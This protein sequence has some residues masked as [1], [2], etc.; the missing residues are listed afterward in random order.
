MFTFDKI[1]IH[2]NSMVVHDDLFLLGTCFI[3]GVVVHQ[4]QEASFSHE[5]MTQAKLGMYDVGI[6]KTCL[7]I[8]MN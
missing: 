7:N 1:M 8:T 2:G 4:E 6:D 5:P 3:V